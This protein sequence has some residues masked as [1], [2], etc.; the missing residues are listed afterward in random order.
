MASTLSAINDKD[1]ST[2]IFILLRQESWITNNGDPPFS[3]N[4]DHLIPTKKPAVCVTYVQKN[5][6]LNPQ[7][8]AKFKNRILSIMVHMGSDLI[9]IINIYAPQEKK[10]R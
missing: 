1:K 6:K 2:D 10:K 3:M 8:S 9:E 4:F 5:H 7:I